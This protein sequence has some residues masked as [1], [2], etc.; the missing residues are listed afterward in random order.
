MRVC[1]KHFS[2]AN[3]EKI[4]EIVNNEPTIS[5][6]S[7]SQRVCELLNW[8]SPNGKLQ[9]GGCR[10]AL[11]QLN[12][13]G[14]VK[15]PQIQKHY[16]FENVSEKIIEISIPEICCSLQELGEVEI[17][18]IT[19]R[20]SKDAQIWKTLIE[21]YHY[22]GN[23]TLCGASLRYL[24]KSKDHG[25]VG[26]LSFSSATFGLC[27]RDTYIGWSEPA[28][29]ANLKYVVLNSRFLILPSVE[30]K[31]LASHVLSLTIKRLSEDW[32]ARYNVRP[33]LVET[34]V[35][36]SRFDGTCY[37]AS[38]WNCVGKTSGRR[39]GIEKEIYLYALSRA[40]KEVLCKETPVRFGEIPRPEAASSWA[41]EEWCHQRSDYAVNLPV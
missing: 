22:L 19:N 24:V 2:C 3:I 1:G 23:G 8:R 26:A 4:Q 25:Y 31:C 32:Y 37:K 16:S 40:R 15:L 21:R 20:R 39:D 17:L 5:R 28:R 30:V 6:T 12:R 9:Q 11:A 14:V 33:V 10:K 29:I 27:E 38:N 13:E 35:D 36:P 18:P 34:F 7:L 41:E